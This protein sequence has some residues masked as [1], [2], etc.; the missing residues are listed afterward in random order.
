MI[1]ATTLLCAL[2]AQQTTL[3]KPT[4]VVS[5]DGS[6]RQGVV[7][8]VQDG[9]ILEVTEQPS[10]QGSIVRL[11]GVLAPG[12]VDAFSGRGADR[13]LTEQSDVSSSDLRA[14]D[15]LDLDAPAWEAMLARG[16]TAINITPDPTNVLAGHGVVMMTGGGDRRLQATSAQVASLL[17]S[18]VRDQRVG[19][20]SIA[21]AVERLSHALHLQQ[22][23]EGVGETLFFVEDAAGVSAVED[24][25]H[26]QPQGRHFVLFGDLASYAG[27][28]QGQLVGLPTFGSGMVARRAETMK[29]LNKAGT[30]FA[31]GSRG[32]SSEWDSLRLSA[33]SFSR[34]SGD[35]AAA[36]AAITTHP[37][38]VLGLQREIG[39]IAPGLRADLV[40]WSAHPLDATAEV[41]AVMIGGETVYRTPMTEETS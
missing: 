32:G 26:G 36:W 3:L 37:A 19:P 13:V 35:P 23:Q 1:L 33:M 29:R 7:V 20:T 11:D 31:F 40:L 27:K 8:V 30:R 9:R 22:G 4:A 10:H 38:E 24:L 25:M 17:V 39:S 21:G 14:A 34:F 2:A 5:P 28:I 6:L 41:R 16:I 12:L 18:S 15:G